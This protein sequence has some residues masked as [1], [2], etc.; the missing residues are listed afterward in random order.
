MAV[1]KVGVRKANDQ[2][3]SVNV[4]IQK[5]ADQ[6]TKAPGSSSKQ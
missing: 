4:D 2:M 1:Y 3:G 5:Q 6:M